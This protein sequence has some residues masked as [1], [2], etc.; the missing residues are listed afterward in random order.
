MGWALLLAWLLPSVAGWAAPGAGY[1]AAAGEIR[2][3]GL[4]PAERAALLSGAPLR[5]QIAGLNS[6]RGMPLSIA[7]TGAELRVTPRFALKPGTRYTLRFDL[8]SARHALTVTPPALPEEAPALIGFDPA[9]AVIPAN[10]LRLYL[11]FSTPMARGQLRD[12]LTLTKADGTPVERPFL[13]L[14][15]E[16]WDHDQTRATLLLDPGRIKQG[17]GPNR[18][19]GAPLQAGEAYQLTLAAR[20]R[21]AAGAPM[22]KPSRMTFRVGP[23]EQTA[24]DPATWQ[25][26]PPPAGS[27]A[28]LSITFDR[29][30]DPATLRR[31][32]TLQDPQGRRVRGRIASD[33]GGWSLTPSAPWQT[34]R[35]TLR[36][37]PAL[38]DIAGNRIAA[39]FDAPPGTMGTVRHAVEHVVDIAPTPQTRAQVCRMQCNR[40]P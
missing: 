34:G 15:T 8:A 33:G 10:T 26:A 27:H 35:Y 16:L 36:L 18:I 4:S 13:S 28:P 30:M 38:E 21:S 1:D 7:E 12:A 24:I 39:P 25:V 20:M 19:G 32:L 37:D 3:T 29:I 31:L 14:A 11:H 6:T 9:Q 5:L 23:P 17:V 2:V 40:S 22:G